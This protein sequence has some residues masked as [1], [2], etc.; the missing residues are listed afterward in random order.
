MREQPKANPSP[1]RREPDMSKDEITKRLSE[2]VGRPF[3]VG[4]R[5]LRHAFGFKRMEGERLALAQLIAPSKSEEDLQTAPDA[6]VHESIKSWC[7]DYLIDWQYDDMSQA[8]TFWCEGMFNALQE[9][10][11]QKSRNI[12]MEGGTR[13]K[14]TM[15]V[16]PVAIARSAYQWQIERYYSAPPTSRNDKWKLLDL[17]VIEALNVDHS[18]IEII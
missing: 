10:I 2:T 16:L 8:Y 14:P 13:R 3:I 18:F 5:S 12:L 1:L 6:E 7:S 9:R 4:F 11:H 15:V 17:D